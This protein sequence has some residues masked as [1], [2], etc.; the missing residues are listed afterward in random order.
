VF[1]SSSAGR[2]EL[3]PALGKLATGKLELEVKDWP[4]EKK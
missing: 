3:D 4:P 2:L 1:G